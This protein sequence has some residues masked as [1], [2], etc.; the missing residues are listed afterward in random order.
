MV[1]NYLILLPNSEGKSR[2]GDEQLVYRF[3]SNLN[4]Y[5]SFLKL[6][7]IRDYIIDEIKKI[8]RIKMF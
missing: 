1:P 7:P 3:V 2:G 5:N 4:K 6:Q 8:I